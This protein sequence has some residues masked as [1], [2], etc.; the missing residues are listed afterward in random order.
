[1]DLYKHYNEIETASLKGLRICLDDIQILIDRLDSSVFKTNIV[2]YSEGLASIYTIKFGNGAIKVLMWTQM[3]GDESTSTKSIFDIFTFVT[4]DR[5]TDV[6]SFLLQNLTIYVVPILNPDGA[7][8]YTRENGKNFDLNR[9]AKSLIYKESQVLSKLI[10]L[11]NPD[12]A[13]NLHDQTS[14]YNVAATENVA[15]ISLLAPSVD[16][17]DSIPISRQKA[18]AV[19][20][21]INKEL[22]KFIPNHIGR[23]DDTFCENCFGDTIQALGI[24]TILIEFGYFPNDEF[25]EETRKLH[26]IAILKALQSI[27]GGNLS[28][29]KD[30]FNIPLNEKRFYDKKIENVLYNGKITNLGLRYKYTLRNNQMIK[31]IDE[32]ETIEGDSLKNMLFHEIFDAKGDEFNK[33]C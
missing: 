2:G 26:T 14:Y 7:A 16:T 6:N 22:Q 5:F 19:I 4:S 15:T 33:C 12:Y 17:N 11:I 10:K 18:M 29:Y 31:I 32:T 20:S 28:D 1:M 30:Y 24:P 23:Y 27:A 13:F 21:D 8:N 25:R 3:H 9:D